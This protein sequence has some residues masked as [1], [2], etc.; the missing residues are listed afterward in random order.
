MVPA[1]QFFLPANLLL[2]TTQIR[3]R[4]ALGISLPMLTRLTIS[5]IASAIPFSWFPFPV[6]FDFSFGYLVGRPNCET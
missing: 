2:H 4:T 1:V 3:T 6:P 5:A